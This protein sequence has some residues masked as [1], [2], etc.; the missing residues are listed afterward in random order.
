MDRITKAYM[1]VFTALILTVL[2]FG[3]AYSDAGDMPAPVDILYDAPAPVDTLFNE[4]PLDTSKDSIAAPDDFI[5]FE[6]APQP[7]PDSSPAP[8]YPKMALSSGVKGK[9]V[10]QVYVNKS[11]DVGKY[12]IKSVKPANLGFE[13]EVIRVLGKWK[14]TPA[15]QNGKPI[16]VW[17]EIPFNFDLKK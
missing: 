14:F 7:L 16:G 10:V 3:N 4:S 9:V 8:A 5:P 11:G 1:P 15:I 12:L 6:V 2:C 17:V 13:D